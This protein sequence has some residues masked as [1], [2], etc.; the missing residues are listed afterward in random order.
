MSVIQITYYWVTFSGKEQQLDHRT[1]SCEQFPTNHI[2]GSLN[3]QSQAQTS[4][5]GFSI[6]N[7]RVLLKRPQL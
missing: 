3:N 1:Q 7:S 4:Q 6:P 2:N 5:P